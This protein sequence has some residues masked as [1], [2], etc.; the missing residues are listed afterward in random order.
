[1]TKNLPDKLFKE[2]QDVL[3]NVALSEGGCQD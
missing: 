2:Q 1:M 3:V